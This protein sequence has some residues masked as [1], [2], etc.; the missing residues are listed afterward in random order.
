MERMIMN[1]LPTILSTAIEFPNFHI[2]IE[3]LP[4]SFN[5]FGL[6]VAFYGLII[7]IGI[8]AGIFVACAEAKHTGQDYNQYIDFSIYAILFSV[9]GARL[10]YVAFSWD[11]YS[12]HPLEIINIRGGGL[13]IYG[14]V[15]AALI[16]CFVYT[17]IK[18]MSF[19]KVADTGILG[20]IVGQ[21][22]GRWGNFFNREAFGGVASDS[23]PWAMRIYF[24]DNY[25]ISQAPEVVKSGMES[26]RG[27]ALEE[28]GYIQVQ[29]TFLYES[30][31]NLFVLILILIFRGKKKF[32]GEILLWYLIGYGLGR[33]VIEGFRTDQLL[34]P[35]TGW[36]VSQVLSIVLVI[37]AAAIVVVKRVKMIK[38]EE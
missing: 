35:V 31:W 8:L 20:L 23:N 12:R 37:V 3:N 18:K 21:I 5:L 36:P 15:I 32:D 34:M 28:I 30:L 26:L 25:H 11:Y 29:P 38:N 16:T 19:R 2:T 14:A 27:K 4:K 17:R 7:A 9:L 22:I 33:T 13:A 24:D 6:D 10:Y 1:I